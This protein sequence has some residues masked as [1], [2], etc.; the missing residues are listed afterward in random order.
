MDENLHNDNL[1]RFFKEN[2]E[3][4]SPTPSSDFWARM[5]PAI[6]PKPSAWRGFSQKYLKWVGLGLLLLTLAILLVF[7]Q[8]DRQRIEQ[9]SKQIA[10]AQQQVEQLSKGQTGVESTQAQHNRVAQDGENNEYVATT[11][12]RLEQQTKIAEQQQKIGSSMGGS[13]PNSIKPNNS[14]KAAAIP[15]Q[16]PVQNASDIQMKE[17]LVM[18]AELAGQNLPTNKASIER[19]SPPSTFDNISI[20][21]GSMDAM[22]L[23]TKP[24]YLSFKKNQAPSVRHQGNRPFRKPYPRISVEAGS[25]AFAMPLAR[26]FNRDTNYAGS[27]RPSWGANFALHYELSPTFALHG[28]YEFKNIRTSKMALR[29]HSVPLLVAQK[30]RLGRR[31]SFEAKAGLTINK[32]FNFRTYSDGLSVRG[33]KNI[34]L[35]WQASAQFGIPMSKDVLLLI[36]PYGGSGVTTFANGKRTWE[37]GLATNIRYQF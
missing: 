1:E 3:R 33:R 9:L 10:I 4:Y 34:W 2:L 26:L 16:E 35:G 22:T 6:P 20:E 14:F 11:N 12:S 19:V 32:Y 7:W 36:G 29:Y 23:P 24:L 21:Q 37:A 25:A 8:K 27:I 30:L 18:P 15:A 28:G 5:E 13:V 17:Q 31:L